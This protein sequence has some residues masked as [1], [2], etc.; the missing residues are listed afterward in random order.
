M[1]A[2]SEDYKESGYEVNLDMDKLMLS[3]SKASGDVQETP[4]QIQP[5]ND[6]IDDFVLASTTINKY[7]SIMLKIQV[8]KKKK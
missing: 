2:I 3:A 6:N 8:Y 7:D 5:T 1:L 4:D